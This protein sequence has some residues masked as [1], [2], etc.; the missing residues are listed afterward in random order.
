MKKWILILLL[1][2]GVAQAHQHEGHKH[3]EHKA[4][5][6]GSGKLAI[7]F[8]GAKGEIE[9]EAAA[10]GV[11]G[12]E[13]QAK[14]DK[15]KKME[16]DAVALFETKI[17]EMVQFD[18]ALKCQIQKEEIKVHREGKHADFEAEFKVTCEKSP[19]GSTITVD[20]SSV[21]KIKSVEITA[22]VG[23]VQKSAT[24]KKQPVKIELK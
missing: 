16:A 22:L 6:H 4:H 13:H 23:A 11:I 2:A 24:F 21:K 9:F 1:V 17:S 10:E 19:E 20:F 18:A 5:Q 12:F 8:E 15:D 3:R 7:A 14:S